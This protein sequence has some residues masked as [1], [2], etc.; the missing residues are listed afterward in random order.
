MKTPKPATRVSLGL[1]VTADL[2]NQLD[3]AARA[4]GRTQ[5]QEAEKR[6]EQSFR[7]QALLNQVLE[8]AYGKRLGGLLLLIGRAMF[9]AGRHSAFIAT[10]KL[11]DVENWLDNAYGY[12]QAVQAAHKVLEVLRPK[13]DTSPPNLQLSEVV[14]SIEGISSD[15]MFDSL[16]KNFGV[17]VANGLFYAL[18]G[19]ATRES[20]D[21]AEPVSEM[22][23]PMVDRIKWGETKNER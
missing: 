15:E 2:K 23:G 3:S 19:R 13:G 11:K 22:L 17:T 6:L 5:S 14:G 20:K 21:W 7:D 8:L 9:D 1:K 12:D 16:L 4:S 10:R 18:Q